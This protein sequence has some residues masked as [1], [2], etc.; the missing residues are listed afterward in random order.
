MNYE[1]LLTSGRI[2][3]EIDFDFNEAWNDLTKI[4]CFK[5][6]KQSISVPIDENNTCTIP[7]ELL[8]SGERIMVAAYGY[9]DNNSL[10]LP[11]RYIE[12]GIV[13][14]GA[15]PC[16]DDPLPPSPSIL[17]Q[18]GNLNDLETNNKNN[19]VS[20]INETADKVFYSLDE[21]EAFAASERAHIGQ[22][23]TVIDEEN[24]SVTLYIIINEEGQLE[25][26]SGGTSTIGDYNALLNQPKINTVT[27]V[28][29]KTTEELNLDTKSVT[30][31]EI[32]A[33]FNE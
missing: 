12:L 6:S 28:G 4:A 27:L 15:D 32:E 33:L 31:S 14:I 2:G 13:E 17:M 11:T 22:A 3:Q 8:L 18:I 7:W 24:D 30:N 20:A 16:G 10:V 1:I 5:N 21:A 26:L 29:D 25:P 9:N 19:L 23:L